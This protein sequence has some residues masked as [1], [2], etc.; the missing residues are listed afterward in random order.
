MM[1]TGDQTGD[2]QGWD[3]REARESQVRFKVLLHLR[4]AESTG[5]ME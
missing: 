4:E 2:S 1:T 5:A 3:L